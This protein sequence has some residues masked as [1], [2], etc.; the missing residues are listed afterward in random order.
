MTFVLQDIRSY[1]TTKG[2]SGV[3]TAKKSEGS[4]SKPVNR[5]KPVLTDSSSEDEDRKAA[6]KSSEKKQKRGCNTANNK[7][8]S[9]VLSDSG[10][11][12]STS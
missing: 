8:R 11:Y 2:G 4:I 3:T 5:P 12:V 1:F 6:R 9:K 10:N 7:K